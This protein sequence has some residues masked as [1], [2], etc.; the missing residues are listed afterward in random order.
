[1]PFAETKR[2]S[3]LVR[4]SCGLAAVLGGLLWVPYGAFEMLKPWGVDTVYREDLGYEVVAAALLYR[5]Y[6][7]PGG[8]ALLLT[9]IGLFGVFGPLGLPAGRTGRTSL[10]LT[11]VAMALAVLSV[12]GVVAQFDPLFTGPRIFG[13]LALGVATLLTGVGA[14]RT[15]AASSWT[16]ALV[17]VGLLG[18]FLLP[19][20]PLVFAVEVVSEVAGAGVIALFGLG[21]ALV[22]N[23][24]WSGPGAAEGRS[25]P[26]RASCACAARER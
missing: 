18:L 15:G 23:L 9:A 2:A 1:L 22:G 12:V 14:R 11:Y 24:L 4:S 10:G 5:V 17:A 6:S 19:L 25:P 7:L 16:S 3:A 13:T 8:L 20:W 26:G 21:W